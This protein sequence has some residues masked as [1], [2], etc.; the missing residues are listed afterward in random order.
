MDKLQRSS[1][2]N[3]EPRPGIDLHQ[4]RAKNSG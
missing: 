2:L 3:V 1:A 4:R